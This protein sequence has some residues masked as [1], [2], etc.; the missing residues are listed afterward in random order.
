MNL[1]DAETARMALLI[2]Q[3]LDVSRID[4]GHMLINPKSESIVTT[5]QTTL[6]TY[7]PVFS[8]NHNTLRFKKEG[9]IPSV[10]YDR[11]RIIQVLVNLITNAAR[12]TRKGIITVSVMAN[13]QY[14]TISI[15]D[16]G[17]GISPEHLP[18]LFERYYTSYSSS[19][20]TSGTGNTGT[21]LGLYIC[22]YIVEAHGGSISAESEH[23]KGT[24]IIFTLPLAKPLHS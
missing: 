1:I 2:S 21:G 16:N 15:T 12:H 3:L 4:E 17:D 7:Y 18:Y 10:L 5:I 9:N 8:K 20:K 24:R 23:G 14:I 22:K 11:D 6:D 19:T 13:N